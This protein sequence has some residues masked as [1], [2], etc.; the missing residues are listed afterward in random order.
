M[1][2]NPLVFDLIWQIKVFGEVQLIVFQIS[3]NNEPII[4]ILKYE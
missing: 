4:S 2:R 1:K 3:P